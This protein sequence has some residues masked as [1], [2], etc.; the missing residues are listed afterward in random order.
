MKMGETWAKVRLHGRKDYR[1]VEMLVDTGAIYTKI[2]TSLA[3]EIG[4]IPDEAVKM[5]LAD[6]SVCDAGVGEARVE[7]GG[8][9]IRTIPVLVGPGDQLL[10]GV[11]TLEILRLKVNPVDGKL[12][13]FIPYLFVAQA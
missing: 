4:V 3:K 6:G 5:R 10:L 1:D 9:A 12:E 11:T 13:P 8:M 7:Y 2:S